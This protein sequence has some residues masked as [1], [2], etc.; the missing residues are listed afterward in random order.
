MPCRASGEIATCRECRYL[1]IENV[2]LIE[3]DA[4]DLDLPEAS[5]DVVVSNLGINNFANAD[6]VLRTCFR[7]TKPGGLLLLTANLV[8][9][10]QEFYDVY[11]ATLMELELADRLATLDAHMNHR[12]TLASIAAQLARAGFALLAVAT[13]SYRMR[14]ANRSSFL[15]H[16]FVRR[17]SSRLGRLWCRRRPWRE[18]LL[19]VPA[20]IARSAVAAVFGRGKP[21]ALARETV[22]WL[23]RSFQRSGDAGKGCRRKRTPLSHRAERGASFA[24]RCKAANVLQA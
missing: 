11:R 1:G 23:A 9:H 6:A 8:G 13:D 15:R 24:R 19:S 10:M 12:A 18:R 22:W 4:A 2:R 3:H 7:V 20:P 21:N 17:P 16:A 5:I 14:C